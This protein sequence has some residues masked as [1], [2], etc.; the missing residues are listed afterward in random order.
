MDVKPSRTSCEQSPAAGGPWRLGRA[1]SV[2]PTAQSCWRDAGLQGV[3]PL[4]PRSPGSAQATHCH[5]P[6]SALGEGGR[7]AAGSAGSSGALGSVLGLLSL[8]RLLAPGVE[9]QRRTEGSRVPVRSG[10]GPRWQA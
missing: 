3:P 2:P 6:G 5:G 9:R 4:S 10:A 8:M 7:Q 1:S